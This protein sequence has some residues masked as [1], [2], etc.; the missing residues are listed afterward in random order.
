[1]A[2]LGVLNSTSAVL[3]ALTASNLNM[4]TTD[5]RIPPGSLVSSTLEPGL[6]VASYFASLIGCL[7]T[8]EILH[9]RGTG[10]QN[11]RSWYVFLLREHTY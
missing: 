4:S 11:W 1:M 5:G 2:P 6:V 7:L 10:L 9:R 3:T 8:I